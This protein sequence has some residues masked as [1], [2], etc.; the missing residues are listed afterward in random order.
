MVKYLFV[1]GGFL[2]SMVPKTER[3]F[4]V[5]LSN[6]P[7]DYRSVAGGFARTFYYDA[8]PTVKLD[9]DPLVFATKLRAKEKLFA[10]VNQTPFMHTREGI[11]RNRSTRRV[12]QQ[13]GVDILLAIDV[14]KHASVRNMDEAHI[15]TCDLDFFPLFE[16]LRDTPVSVHLHCYTDET[17]PELMSLADVVIPI[18]PFTILQWMHHG[19]R[20][21][22]VEWNVS[23][24]DLGEHELFKEGIYE[25]LPFH[26]FK[27]K[28][29][30]ARPF[31]SRAMAHNPGNLMRSER[32]EFAVADFES[33]V[34]KRVHF[35]DD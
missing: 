21:R 9:E 35:E 1:D 18:N 23:M 16:A 26:I 13:K 19:S 25:G 10:R 34:Q 4:E 12:L 15:M 32:W 24:N 3:F 6:Y 27:T 22:L 31:F 7:I 5:S 17:S 33:R 28:V 20:D 14:F 29:P 2:E 8:T 30:S 11:T